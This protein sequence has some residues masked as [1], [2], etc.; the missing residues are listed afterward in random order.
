VTLE[1][2]QREYCKV[3]RLAYP[4]EDAGFATSWMFFRL[5]VIVQGVAARH[6]RRQASSEKAAQQGAMFPLFGLMARQVTLESNDTARDTLPAA[7][8]KL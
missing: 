2:L 3:S 4:I 1:D 7:K 5:A 8:V 6:A